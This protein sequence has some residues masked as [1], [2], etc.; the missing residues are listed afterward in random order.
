MN[1]GQKVAAILLGIILFYLVCCF[2]GPKDLN[3][4]RNIDVNNNAGEVF[5][6]VNT[7]TNW[8]KWSPWGEKD[9][10]MKVKYNNIPS[11]V[12]SS[13]SWVGDKSGSGK[14]E[15][16]ESESGKHIKTKLL[17]EGFDAPSFGSWNF[18]PQGKGTKLSWGMSMDNSLPFMIRGMMWLT[19]QKKKMTADFDKGLANIKKL[20]EA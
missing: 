7:L 14:L 2:M 12:G 10:S 18:V 8:E 6:L 19:G 3:V 5:E 11:G 4:E 9:P 13:Y 16:L 1:I 15:I 17:F 20:A